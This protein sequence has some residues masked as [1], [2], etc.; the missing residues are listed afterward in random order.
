MPVL[1]TSGGVT[2]MKGNRASYLLYFK[3]ILFIFR[4]K[5]RE[6]E[7]QGQKRQCE[8]VSHS[9]LTGDLACN[10]GMCPDWVCN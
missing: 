8:V 1:S 2:S 4:E 5:V 10:P 7:G 3:K 6:G 9:P